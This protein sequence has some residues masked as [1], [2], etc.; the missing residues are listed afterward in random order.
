M[1]LVDT[2]VWIDHLRRRSERL[3][4]LLEDGLVACHP[5][6]VGELACGRLARR[7]EVLALLQRLPTLPPVS[8]DEALRLVDAQDLAGSGLGWVD[9]HLLA[10]A[11]IAGAGLW[12]ADRRL[13]RVAAELDG[14]AGAG[15]SRS[16]RRDRPRK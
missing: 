4:A 14:T 1:V 16:K 3:A 15:R 11:R 9:V 13:E 5:F 12:T 2:S 7:G 10:A 8:H 6:V